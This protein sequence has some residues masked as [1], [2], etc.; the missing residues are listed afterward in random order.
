ML[1]SLTSL[2]PSIVLVQELVSALR[3]GLEHPLYVSQSLQ[4]VF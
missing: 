1:E 2:N 4:V 3:V